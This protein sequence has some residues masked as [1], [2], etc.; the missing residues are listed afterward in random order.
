VILA[1][2]IVRLDQYATFTLYVLRRGAVGSVCGGLRKR[3]C[4]EE[5]V[6]KTTKKNKNGERIMKE[7]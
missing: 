4:A 6:K 1:G 3:K 5:E 7:K 2:L